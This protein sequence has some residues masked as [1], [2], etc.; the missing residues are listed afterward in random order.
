MTLCGMAS[1]VTAT[2]WSCIAHPPA[3]SEPDQGSA[4]FWKQEDPAMPYRRWCCSDRQVAVSKSLPPH[5]C[6]SSVNLHAHLSLA[7]VFMATCFTLTMALQPEEL[8]HIPHIPIFWACIFFTRRGWN[9]ALL[10]VQLAHFW[11]SLVHTCIIPESTMLCPPDAFMRSL[12]LGHRLCPLQT[13]TSRGGFHVYIQL[14]NLVKFR[15]GSHDKLP[16]MAS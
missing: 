9:A 11:K 13:I 5:A 7:P 10:Y 2:T 4:S 6:R 12:V 8:S 15:Q 14:Q 16:A 3:D 1:C